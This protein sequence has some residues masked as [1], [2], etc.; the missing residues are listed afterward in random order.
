MA[1]PG[2]RAGEAFEAGVRCF[3]AGA[4]FEAHERFEEV[5]RS[6]ETA[7]EDR[8]FWKG[9]TQAAVACCHVTRGNAR[10]A[11]TLAR[12]AARNLRGYPS[13]HRGVDTSALV[14]AMRALADAVRARGCRPPPPLLPFPVVAA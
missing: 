10:G 6:S 11:A 13:P 9:V 2:G 4:F 14:A 1:T 12:R 5:W 7:A 8:A 3:D